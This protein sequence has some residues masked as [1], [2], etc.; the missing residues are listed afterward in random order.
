MKC[1]RVFLNCTIQQH[2]KLGAVPHE[3]FSEIVEA[4]L[5]GY[6]IQLISPGEKQH[7]IIQAKWPYTLAVTTGMYSQQFQVSFKC[8]ILCHVP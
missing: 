6:P 2:A 5:A 7:L 1:A 8:T 4:A 3:T